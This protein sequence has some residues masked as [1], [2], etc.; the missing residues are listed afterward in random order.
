MPAGYKFYF[1]SKFSGKFLSNAYEL[2]YGNRFIVDFSLYLI[3]VRYDTLER[4]GV[5]VPLDRFE[6]Y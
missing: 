3:Q 4:N 6:G 2:A 5:Y 1:S